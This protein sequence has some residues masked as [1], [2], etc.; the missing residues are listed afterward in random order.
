MHNKLFLDVLARIVA[1][2][3]FCAGLFI[4][5]QAYTM[6]FH[7]IYIDCFAPDGSGC[8]LRHYADPTLPSALYG[9]GLAL[10]ALLTFYLGART[11]RWLQKRGK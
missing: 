6:A 10:L 9:T 3:L 5:A 1:T 11:L 8:A 7:G 2:V 4:V